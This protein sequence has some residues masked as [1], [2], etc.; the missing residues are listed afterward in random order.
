MN[1]ANPAQ[2]VCDWV[3]QQW[4]ILRGRKIDA[5]EYD[6][7]LGPFGD[8]NGIGE[9]YIL[10][11]AQKENL[12]VDRTPGQ[13]G[14][15]PSIE[16]LGLPG[17]ELDRLSK[18]VADFYEHTSEY[19]LDFAVQWNPVFKF[20]GLLVNRIFSRRLSQLNIPIK[21]SIASE[22]LVS[23]IITLHDPI[24]NQTKYTIWLRKFRKN[25]EVVYSGIYETCVLPSGLTCVKAIF[26]LPN[27]NATVIMKPSVDREG[28]LLLDASGRRIGDPGFYFLL[29]DARGNFWTR[30]LPSF[31]NKLVVSES[32]ADFYAGQTL[33]LWKQK[34]VSFNYK[35]E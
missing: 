6:W 18:K 7:L 29:A 3:T 5:S 4:V 19:K 15:L 9:E 8:L 10:R 24:T 28:G 12:T 1:L 2:N 35:M 17:E 26:P 20:F 34:V 13:K 30:Y 31:T 22:S 21:N 27:G 14:L 33:R 23:E 16:T 25:G 32:G 11:L